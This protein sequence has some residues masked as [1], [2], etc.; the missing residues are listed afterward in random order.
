MLVSRQAG[1]GVEIDFLP[2]EFI[3]GVAATSH[4]LFSAK[5]Y[6]SRIGRRWPNFRFVIRSVPSQTLLFLTLPHC[7]PLAFFNPSGGPLYITAIVVGTLYTHIHSSTKVATGK[8]A[9]DALHEHH[10]TN[11]RIIAG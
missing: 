8:G 10:A 3:C 2:V 7:R 6:L 1:L 9:C 4:V 11:N 5:L